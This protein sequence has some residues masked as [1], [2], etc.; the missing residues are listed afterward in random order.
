MLLELAMPVSWLFRR[1]LLASPDIRLHKDR[2]SYERLP[3]GLSKVF[4]ILREAIAGRSVSIT[5]TGLDAGTSSKLL[6]LRGK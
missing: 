2:S 3:N 5:G 1:S 4:P 6:L